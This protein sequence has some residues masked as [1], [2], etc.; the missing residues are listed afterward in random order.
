MLLLSIALVL[1]TAS[2]LAIVDDHIREQQDML[3]YDIAVSI[4]NRADSIVGATRLLYVTHGG[5]G[6]LVLDF[7]RALAID[8]IL[9]GPDRATPGD[10]WRWEDN[11]VEGGDLLEIDHWSPSGDTL[12]VTVHYHGRPRDGLVMQRNVHGAPSV[13]ADNWPNRARHWFPAEDH[14]S[15]KATAEITVEVPAKW[16]AISNGRLVGV[17]SLAGGRTAWQWREDRRIPAYT[18]VLGAARMA[19]TSL[20]RVHGVP[21]SVWTFVEDSTFAI[22]GP[23]RRAA[24]IALVFDSV[25]GPFPYEKLAHVQSSTQFGGMENS[26]A[27][28]YNERGYAR[29]SMGEGVVTHETAHQWFGDAVTEYDWHHLWLSEGFASYFG[30]LFYEMIGDDSTFR[31]RMRAAKRRYL[32]S[33]LVGRPVIDTAEHDLFKLLN[34]NNY[35]KGAWILHMLR[36][37]IGDRAFFAGIRDYYSTYRDS[38]ALSSDFARIMS[39][40]AGRDLNWFFEQWLLQ[41]GYPKL[42]IGWSYDEQG[43]RVLLSVEQTQSTEWGTFALSLPVMLRFPDGDTKT[44]LVNLGTERLSVVR[45][46][47]DVKPVT[48]VPDPDGSLLVEIE[49]VRGGR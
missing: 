32:A 8:S 20:P 9:L 2:P 38:T 45:F 36:G 39:R 5:Q 26:S 16:Q 28:F 27:I 19:I 18:M 44:V 13:F 43:K 37:E 30:P 35:P 49:K 11:A 1:Q 41:P 10:D 21:Q 47:T 25:V 42:D 22:D 34:D 46:S 7:D 14:P 12:S 31:A 48:V 23:F 15:D 29:R 17:D 33:D 40:H 4:S 24:R 6:P 3:H